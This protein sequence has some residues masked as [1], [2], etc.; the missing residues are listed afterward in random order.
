VTAGLALPTRDGALLPWRPSGRPPVA[1]AGIPPRSRTAYAA[2]HVV[3]DPLSPRD[4]GDPSGRAALD[5]DATL[6]FRHHV[7]SCGLGVAEA[8][9][10]AQRGMGLDWATARELIER[11]GVEA[12]AVGGDWCAGVG[13]DQLT[14]EPGRPAGAPA[15]VDDVVAAWREQLDVVAAA[16]GVPVV[17]ASRELAAAAR[18]PDDYHRAYGKLLADA[19]GGVLL[20][21][22]G[23]PFDPALAGY[24]GHADVRAAG[25]ELAALCRDHARAVA[26]VKVSVL[27]AAAEVAFRRELPAGVACLTGDDFSFPSLIAG[28]GHGHSDA[29]LGIFDP[30][31]AVASAALARLDDGDADG[32]RAL[33]DATVPLAREVFRAPTRLY[34][35]GIV[36]LAYLAGHQRHV[37]MVGGLE[38]ARS[39]VHLAEVLRLADAAG[40]LP[41]PDLAVARMRP[42]LAAAGVEP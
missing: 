14:G 26:G 12:A 10:T 3:A 1:P 7:W 21:W 31:A 29:L 23:E 11:T 18:G 30:I 34:K 22:L 40:V 13:T 9:D 20:H 39:L 27:D 41:D 2:V 17:M 15:T 32:F 4:P 37:R 24:W 33:L 28:D 5:W 16:G 25:R 6:S 19:P 42:V 38:S 8:M 35:V 36:F